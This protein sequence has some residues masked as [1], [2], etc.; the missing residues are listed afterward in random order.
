MKYY[1]IIE[2][3]FLLYF[4]HFIGFINFK[5]SNKIKIQRKLQ[6]S[7]YFYFVILY[8]NIKFDSDIILFLLYYD[9]F[10]NFKYNRSRK[11]NISSKYNVNIDKIIIQFKG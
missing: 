8:R 10:I 9:I 4:D 2:Q 1:N 7:L 6:N 5:Y 3:L 11:I